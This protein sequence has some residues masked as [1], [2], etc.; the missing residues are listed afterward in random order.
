MSADNA[1]TPWLTWVA[2]GACHAPH[3]A[4]FDLIAK[5][6]ALFAEG[7]DVERDAA[8][9]AADR[10]WAS[11]RKGTRLPP[12]ND[13]VRP[14][15]DAARRREAALHA[16]AGGLCRDARPCRPASRA[17][18]GVPRDAG[19]ARRHAGHRHVRQRRQPGGRAVR[20][21]QR[22]GPLQPA[23]RAA[24]GED[25]AHRRHRR[26]RHA[27]QLPARAGRWRPT[28]RCAAT[29]RTPMAAASA[30]RW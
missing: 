11:C 4:P 16:P 15:A 1:E 8:P 29:S 30:I 2:L 5:Y 6:D 18:D 26:S 3:Q 25:R 24:R 27:F 17:A 22:H 19:P 7:W 20:H 28:R 13:A 9:R 23:P 10:D 14:W 21:G 12:R